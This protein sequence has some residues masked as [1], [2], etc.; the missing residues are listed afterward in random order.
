MRN[1]IPMPMIVGRSPKQRLVLALVII[2]FTVF[3][4]MG[5]SSVNPITGEAQH[6][7]LTVDQEIALGLQSAPEMAKQHGGLDQDQALQNIVKR[8]GYKLLSTGV[9]TELPYKFDF[10]LLADKQVLNAFALPGGQ[11][12]ITRALLDK[13]PTEDHLAG[14]LAH[15]I[16]HVIE[17]HGAQ[18]LAKANL[19]QGLAQAAGIAVYVPDKPATAAGAQVAYAIG[20]LINLKYN[21]ADELESDRWAVRLTAKSAYRPEA[22][23]EVMRIL[24]ESSKGG[25]PPEFFSTHPASENR[26]ATIRDEI[27]KLG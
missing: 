11:V 6:V 9:G 16:G 1:R 12:F 8:V 18:H 10:H 19:T 25:R 5:S 26:V 23:I 24:S 4:Y 17:R 2:A 15:E 14:V 27:R 20:S 7:S 22:M 21:R 3:S 13:L